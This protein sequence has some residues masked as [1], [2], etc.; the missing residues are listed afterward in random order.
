M[1]SSRL[2][3]SASRR[4]LPRTLP[5]VCHRGVVEFVDVVGNA[6]SELAPCLL[7]ERFGEALFELVVASDETDARCWAL[8]NSACR[9]ARD[10]AGLPPGALRGWAF[11]HG[12]GANG[13]VGDHA[14][15]SAGSNGRIRRTR[16]ARRVTARWVRTVATARSI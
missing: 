3:G 11:G 9:G 1:D 8:C 4:R 13:G 5:V 14:V 15:R 2:L 10:T 12:G 6:E 16:G 7:A